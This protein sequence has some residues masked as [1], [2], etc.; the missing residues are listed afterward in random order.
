MALRRHHIHSAR[1][2]LP[3]AQESQ[4]PPGRCFAPRFIRATKRESSLHYICKPKPET[5]NPKPEIQNKVQAAFKP[6]SKSSLHIISF[7]RCVYSTV[8]A[9]S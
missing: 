6:S 3:V 1:H 7:A 9:G 2:M 5:R 8:F 4:K